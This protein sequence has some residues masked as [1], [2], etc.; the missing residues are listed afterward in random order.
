[1]QAEIEIGNGLPDIRTTEQCFD[2][3][4]KAGFEVGRKA[5]HFLI[6]FLPKAACLR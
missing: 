4:K 1:M 6:Y 2:A 5:Q 3:L